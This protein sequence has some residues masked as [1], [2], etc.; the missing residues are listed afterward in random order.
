MLWGYAWM[1][2]GAVHLRL[3][4]VSPIHIGSHEQQLRSGIEFIREGN[5][6]YVIDEKRLE[7]QLLEGNRLKDFTAQAGQGGFNLG[8]F[9]RLQALAAGERDKL[10]RDICSS[11]SV[12]PAS[13]QRLGFIRP[14]VRDAYA[15][16]YVPE[17]SLKGALRIA[18]LYCFLKEQKED[19]AFWG[20]QMNRVRE[21]LHD[22]RSPERKR[23]TLGG[24]LDE[25]LQDFDLY[26]D[27]SRIEPRPQPQQTDLFRALDIHELS[28][29]REV[30][31]EIREVR[32]VS[33]TSQDAWKFSRRRSRAPER[34]AL[35]NPILIY[36]ELLMP[37]QPPFGIDFKVHIDV[38]LWDRFRPRRAMA[39][40]K[41]LL[42]KRAEQEGSGGPQSDR[43]R[44]LMLGL[45][46]CCREFAGDIYGREREWFAALEHGD[47][48]LKD[49]ERFYDAS[50]QP[51]PNIR[52][53]WGS[54]MLTTGMFSLIEDR[55]VA[56][57]VA[58][59]FPQYR[60]GW[61]PYGTRTDQDTIFDLFPKTR[62]VIME[63]DTPT[64]PP[65]WAQVEVI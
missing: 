32:I 58:R 61:T 42:E 3:T 37:Q 55:D 39:N 44:G 59:L 1:N 41:E 46:S 56:R 34:L 27:G 24:F 29:K 40:P 36:P 28:P 7:H 65:G 63:K 16:P 31:L 20:R 10:L 64:H 30:P 14:F 62:R 9:F 48:N 19:R 52:I 45:L 60:R 47:A 23:K 6:C 54:G 50:R 25:F 12:C 43:G 22:R 18:L 15:R 57:D 11:S 5:R 2:K 17:S 51:K 21:V 33:L 13:I 38:E 53:G 26:H 35:E 4:P 8:N 49:L